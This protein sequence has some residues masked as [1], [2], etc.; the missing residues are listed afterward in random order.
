M[1]LLIAILAGAGVGFSAY[2]TIMAL[3]AERDAYRPI[4]GRVAG[5]VVNRRGDG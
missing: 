3:L 4:G 2:H 5:V 1:T